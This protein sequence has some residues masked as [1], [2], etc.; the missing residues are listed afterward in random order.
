MWLTQSMYTTYILRALTFRIQIKYMHFVH[1][2][3][4]VWQILE[5]MFQSMKSTL[6]EKHI[7]SFILISRINLAKFHLI[8]ERNILSVDESRIY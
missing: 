5:N 4:N 7:M 6:L 2:S 1:T 3:R 8:F